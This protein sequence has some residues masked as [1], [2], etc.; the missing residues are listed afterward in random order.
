MA[1]I[2]AIS[3]NKKI[4]VFF[5]DITA[6][7]DE[8]SK[9]H[10]VNAAAKQFFSETA[11]I[12]VLL[13]SDIKD[14]NSTFSAV[15]RA[16]S[17]YNNAVVV[18]NSKNQ[19]KGY[20]NAETLAKYDFKGDIKNNSRLVIINDPGLKNVYT[21]EIPV[22]ADSM[23]ACITDYF[24]DSLQHPGM[25]SLKAD[26]KSSGVL[27]LPVLNS[28][29]FELESRKLELMELSYKLNNSNNA[30]DAIKLLEKYGFIITAEYDV[31]PYCDCDNEKIESVILSLGEKEA[32]DILNEVGKV[33]IVC[34]YCK[35]KYEYNEEELRTVFEK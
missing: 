12:S 22:L 14:E 16:P 28:E 17:P 9:I 11:I 26:D 33:E 24:K 8:I 6:S 1:I 20:C 19:I 29:Y 10:E 23:E 13:S 30:E 31:T 18:C 15:F 2:R 7:V 5:A 27:I 32:F 25:V 34:P 4:R 35:K 3:E 21:T